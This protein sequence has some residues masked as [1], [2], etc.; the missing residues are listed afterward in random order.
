M[1]AHALNDWDE[2][3]VVILGSFMD[4]AIVK[5]L[6]DYTYVKPFLPYIQRIADETYEDL[7]NIQLLLESKGIKVLRPDAAYTEQR[8]REQ[9]EFLKFE[10]NKDRVSMPS[11]IFI[12]KM[13]IPLAP[14]NEIMV[15]G[16][17]VFC[18]GEMPVNIDTAQ[19]DNKIVNS[20]EQGWGYVHWPAITRVNDRLVFGRQVEKHTLE[21]I[22]RECT[23]NPDYI[24]TSIQGHVDASMACVKEGLLL[25]TQ[26]NPISVY[27]ETFPDWKYI[28]CGDNGFRHMVKQMT[29]YIEPTE[30][31][32]DSIKEH[33]NNNWWIKDL[34]QDEN[35][36]NIA[37][38]INTCFSDW[39]GYSEE[40]YFEVNCLTINPDCSIV[41]GE[42]NKIEDELKKHGHECIN[43]Q[44]RNRWFFDQ[45][46]H[47][48]TQDIK[49][50]H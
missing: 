23:N 5:D 28:D 38:V 48:I 9:V 46:L 50:K 16:D 18:N 49:R 47:C 14:R 2:L 21:Q 37:E 30:Q 24:H 25:T 41:I 36:K 11:N 22:V 8:Q 6:F 12:N 40:T 7:N 42:S 19:F 35:A 4:P 27:E 15:Y 29:G 32:I 3:E 43:V 34:E 39:F 31:I 44:W 33:T 13:Q 45:G 10:L 26:R 1:K 17:V 20:A